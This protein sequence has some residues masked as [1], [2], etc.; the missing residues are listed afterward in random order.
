[1]YEIVLWI[2]WI[3]NIDYPWHWSE[4]RKGAKIFV[5]EWINILNFLTFFQYKI[6]SVQLTI[7]LIAWIPMLSRPLP[8]LPGSQP[9]GDKS[10]ATPDDHSPGFH[11]AWEAA[12][13]RPREEATEMIKDEGNVQLSLT[14]KD[15]KWCPKVRWEYHFAS[16]YNWTD[17]SRVLQTK[18]RA[19]A[20]DNVFTEVLI[21]S[22]K[23]GSLKTKKI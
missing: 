2:L 15:W 3:W 10:P 18:S 22:P 20:N 6:F 4:G 8:S 14:R 19:K 13:R 11:P 9:P 23:R 17:E 7:E 12:L 16:Q 1:M 5:S 21:I